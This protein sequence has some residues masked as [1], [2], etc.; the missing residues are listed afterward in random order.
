MAE[1]KWG[2]VM[3]GKAPT[4]TVTLVIEPAEATKGRVVLVGGTLVGSTRI[5]GDD[6]ELHEAYLAAAK[7]LY[8]IS[9]RLHP[10]AAVRSV[11]MDEL[12]RG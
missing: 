9:G 12:L 1:N 8:V 5:V 3:E 10:N 7:A 6:F 2:V 11:T 4:R